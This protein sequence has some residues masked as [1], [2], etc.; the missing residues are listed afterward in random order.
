M[1]L[2]DYAP[3]NYKSPN[4]SDFLLMRMHG[5]LKFANIVVKRLCGTTDGLEHVAVPPLLSGQ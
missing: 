5:R 4:Q 2:L 1:Y 3:G